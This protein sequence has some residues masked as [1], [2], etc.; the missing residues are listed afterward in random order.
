LKFV[1]G[2]FFKKRRAISWISKTK[3]K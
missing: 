3:S 1:K 2:D